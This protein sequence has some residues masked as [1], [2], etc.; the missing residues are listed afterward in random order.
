MEFHSTTKRE[1]QYV[2]AIHHER[3]L[4]MKPSFYDDWDRKTVE[5]IKSKY[6]NDKIVWDLLRAIS[7]KV[8]LGQDKSKTY[9]LFPPFTL[10]EV[11][12]AFRQ[13]NE[14]EVCP[15]SY[16]PLKDTN[17][18]Q[19][20]CGHCFD[21]NAH[22]TWVHT[23]TF[24]NEMVCCPVCRH[25][26]TTRTQVW[27]VIISPA[28]GNTKT[29]HYCFLGKRMA[30]LIEWVESTD[31]RFGVVLPNGYMGRAIYKAIHHWVKMWNTKSGKIKKKKSYTNG[32]PYYVN[33]PEFI[34]IG[35]Q[36]L[37]AVE[38]VYEEGEEVALSVSSWISVGIVEEESL[39][40]WIQS[41]H[42][43]GKIY[44]CDSNEE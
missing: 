34:P 41:G 25:R 4:V 16:N 6:G 43:G 21:A 12:T 36:K 26:I 5:Q 15:I 19:W 20:E 8:P 11:S 38:R 3:F 33:C 13:I 22:W 44:V 9:Y 37:G 17:A 29:L 14:D 7:W 10:Q 39:K 18:I 2:E 24:G 28:Q 31:N 1:K 32:E 40:T 42:M 30:D 27:K 23:K 35:L